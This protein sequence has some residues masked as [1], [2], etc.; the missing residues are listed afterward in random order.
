MYNNEEKGHMCQINLKKLWLNVIGIGLSCGVILSAGAETLSGVSVL[1]AATE[2]VL[3]AHPSA[4][5][6]EETVRAAQNNYKVAR[7][8]YAPT[9][10]VDARYNWGEDE[11]VSGRNNALN[12]P[13]QFDY[14][15]GTVD[16]I[17][18][19]NLFAGFSTQEGLESAREN[20]LAD[21]YR[22]VNLYEALALRVVE[23]YLNILRAHHRVGILS[24]NY[25]EHRVLRD[26]VIERARQGLDR[27]SDIAQA[28]ARVAF[29]LSQLE[30]TI[31]QLASAKAIYSELTGMEVEVSGWPEGWSV[32]GVNTEGEA[33]IEQNWGLQEA[34][35]RADALSAQREVAR[36]ELFP[37]IDLELRSR[38]YEEGDSEYDSFVR[39]AFD[40]NY[41]LTLRLRYDLELGGGDV[42]R[43]RSSASAAT[44][45]RLDIRD[46]AQG[47]R[48]QIKSMIKSQAATK[49]TL[50]PLR[51]YALETAETVK[52]YSQ[53]FNAG[54]RTLL[55]L[56]SATNEKY[57]AQLQE[58]DTL[59][60]QHLLE[61]RINR[62][63]GTLLLSLNL[64]Q[65][66]NI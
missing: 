31:G 56:L 33:S 3:K 51:N 48:E 28:S 45:A 18:T 65:Y 64:E 44:S 35:A 49:A 13:N 63:A 8:A 53:Q 54:R 1:S 52:A 57:T 16:L 26:G 15:G 38:I 5:S 12:A 55:D 34:G 14:Q 30:Q 27:R 58:V 20:I 23:A 59:Y 9:F 17:L 25:E 19:Q 47:L 60:Q 42:Y 22:R 66:T 43:Y 40:T 11:L 36:S 10:S 2:A 24:R 4:K 6:A 32:S 61:A 39:E 7:S 29:I 62:L 37:Q 46:L 21:K 41:L 50:P